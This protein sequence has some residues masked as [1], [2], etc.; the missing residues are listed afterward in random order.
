MA[1]E[2]VVAAAAT[3]AVVVAAAARA[4]VVGVG[5]LAPS[6]QHR[7]RST[8]CAAPSAQHR[9][10][11]LPPPFPQNSSCYTPLP[12]TTIN[13][14][15]TAASTGRKGQGEQRAV[16]CGE[17]AAGGQVQG[18]GEIQAH[19]RS[20]GGRGGS[21]R[22]AGGSGGGAGGGGSGGQRAGGEARRGQ[23]ERIGRARVYKSH[24]GVL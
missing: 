10:A 2:G 21:A 15:T 1:S 17:A 5:P 16:R 18:E 11:S 23:G 22:G 8:E 6:V 20:G 14:I 12:L 4:W 13:T 24:A 7:V 19:G 3:A 9:G